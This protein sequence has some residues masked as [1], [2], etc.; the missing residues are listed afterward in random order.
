[1][2]SSADY[3]KA[4]RFTFDEW[5]N[6]MRSR[7]SYDYKK[8]SWYKAGKALEAEAKPVPPP[9]PPPKPAPALAPVMFTAQDP[10]AVLQHP[11]SGRVA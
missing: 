9:V 8:T 6:L 10:L 2:A 5:C 3:A 11:W 7:A 4:A 1:M